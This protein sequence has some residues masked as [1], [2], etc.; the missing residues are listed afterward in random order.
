MFDDE[1]TGYIS[2]KSLRKINKELGEAITEEEL[3]EMILKADQD[4]DGLVS[5]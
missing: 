1:K 5:E 2:I 3:E 4:N